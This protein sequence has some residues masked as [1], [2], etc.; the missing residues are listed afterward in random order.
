SIVATTYE[1][2]SQLRELI[3]LALSFE[4]VKSQTKS[5]FHQPK[6]P[7]FLLVQQTVAKAEDTNLA[8]L[9]KILASQPKPLDLW[10]INLKV[11]SENLSQ[12]NCIKDSKSKLSNSGYKN[13]LYHCH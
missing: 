12:L 13:R 5:L 6:V 4:R 10:G 3:A 7:Q 8:T 2:S 9:S 11:D 1:T